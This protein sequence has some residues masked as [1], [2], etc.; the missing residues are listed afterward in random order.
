MSSTRATRIRRVTDPW[1]PPRNG[2]HWLPLPEA[3]GLP[4][5][6]LDVPENVQSSPRPSSGESTTQPV[7]TYAMFHCLSSTR[8]TLGIP[9]VINLSRAFNMSPSDLGGLYSNYVSP[10]G[11]ALSHKR[12]SPHLEGLLHITARLKETGGLCIS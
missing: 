7:L 1:K 8:S 3:F 6:T 11:L 5:H 12:L 10:L 4:S 2:L 9:P